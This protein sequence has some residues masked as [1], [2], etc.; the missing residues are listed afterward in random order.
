MKQILFLDILNTR[1]DRI[2]TGLLQ[3][4]SSFVPFAYKKGLIQGLLYVDEWRA[5]F[6]IFYFFFKTLM[7]SL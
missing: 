6:K 7:A 5:S 2:F 4:Y 1:S 3:N